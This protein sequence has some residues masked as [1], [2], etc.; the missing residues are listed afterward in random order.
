MHR[1]GQSF[2]SFAVPIFAA[3]VRLHCD[4]IGKN[5]MLGGK[6]YFNA[7][8]KTGLNP[9]DGCAIASFLGFDE[10]SAIAAI[11]LGIQNAV[12]CAEDEIMICAK[13]G[14]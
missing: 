7:F 2:D 3:Q 14:F 10:P 1:P 11:G 8:H 5:Q 4:A 9:V 12:F 13:M 6:T